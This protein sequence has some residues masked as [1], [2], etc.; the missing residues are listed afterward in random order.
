MKIE[1]RINQIWVGPPMPEHLDECRQTW[2]E[3]HPDWEYRLWG[4]DDILALNP[5]NESLIHEAHELAPEWGY[6]QFVSDVARLEILHEVGGLYADCDW[7]VLR[8]IEPLI[9]DAELFAAWERQDVWIANGLM[10]SVPGHNFIGALIRHLPESV[11]ARKGQRPARMTGPQYLTRMYRQYRPN[12]H[13]IDQDK[14]FPYSHSDLGTPKAE[15]PWPEG[16]YAVHR[17]EN[18]RKMKSLE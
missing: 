14:V 18:M 11:R 16:T 7:Y 2:I 8:N 10:G 6:G 15:P 5:R 17:W 1:K 3:H 12:M 4:L 9:G 13:V